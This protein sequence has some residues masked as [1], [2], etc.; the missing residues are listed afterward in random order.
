MKRKNEIKVRLIRKNVDRK[1]K[2]RAR[3]RMEKI[4]QAN[5]AFIR[6]I[7]TRQ[8]TLPAELLQSTSL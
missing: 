3:A 1:R 7:K 2:N 8:A 4:R 5:R 6:M